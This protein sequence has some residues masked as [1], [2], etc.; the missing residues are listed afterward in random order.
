MLA[1]DGRFVWYR[2]WARDAEPIL[3][4]ADGK[5]AQSLP[6]PYA[7]EAD[8]RVRADLARKR[9]ASAEARVLREFCTPLRFSHPYLESHG[10]D[11]TGCG[12]LRVDNVGW[13]VVPAYRGAEFSS[14]QRI[15][16]DG[17]KRFWPGAPVKGVSYLID[18]SGAS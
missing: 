13:L 11:M 10:L 9:A 14:V 7:G 4:R 3:W 6:P 12:G 2:D 17:Q 5:V 18:R 1:E 8:R 16:P 15:A